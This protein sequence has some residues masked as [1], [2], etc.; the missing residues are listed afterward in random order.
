MS[1]HDPT[2]NA[3]IQKYERSLLSTRTIS[4]S[5]YLHEYS[6]SRYLKLALW[7]LKSVVSLLHL[8][9][10]S[11]KIKTC[12]RLHDRNYFFD[13]QKARMN[14]WFKMNLFSA[15]IHI[16]L[17]TGQESVF[18]LIP[19]K[20]FS[21]LYAVIFSSGDKSNQQL[22]RNVLVYRAMVISGCRIQVSMTFLRSGLLLFNIS[23][24]DINV[25]FLGS[26]F[27]F[28]MN[29]LLFNESFSIDLFKI[30]THFMYT[31]YVGNPQWKYPDNPNAFQGR[32]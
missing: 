21:L 16:R 27:P 12:L 3:D 9:K 1:L 29:S 32:S 13:L 31:F 28:G 25:L 30:G 10:K 8:H 26:T 24:M 2:M 22:R 15:L 19:L 17:R 18:L 14:R 23:K 6:W 20:W 5:F 11:K 4:W 7:S